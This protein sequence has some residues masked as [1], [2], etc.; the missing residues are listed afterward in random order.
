MSKENYVRNPDLNRKIDYKANAL[1]Q[2]RDIYYVI[3]FNAFMAVKRIDEN[4]KKVY[5]GLCNFMDDSVTFI[6]NMYV[7]DKYIAKN[8]ILLKSIEDL[9]KY[10]F[11]KDLSIDLPD[12]KWK[13]GAYCT[14]NEIGDDTDKYIE[15]IRLLHTGV[16]EDRNFTKL[17]SDPAHTDDFDMGDWPGMDDR[18]DY[19]LDD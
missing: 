18:D 15:R 19:L 5:S 7:D 6:D 1:M 12:L 16:F 3:P 13:N 8:C 14:H 17:P 11:Q 2:L 10:A 9:D 4:G